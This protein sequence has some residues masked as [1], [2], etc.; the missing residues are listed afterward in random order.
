LYFCVLNGFEHIAEV[1]TWAELNFVAL[2]ERSGELLGGGSTLVGKGNLEVTK[3]TQ[4][5]DFAL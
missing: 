2:N 3:V 1:C 5:H 4:L